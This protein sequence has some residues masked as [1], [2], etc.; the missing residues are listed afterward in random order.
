MSLFELLLPIFVSSLN[1][2]VIT[3]GSEYRV[4]CLRRGIATDF[5]NLCLN[6]SLLL[7]GLWHRHVFTHCLL[8]PQRQPRLLSKGF[9]AFIITLWE[10]PLQRTFRLAQLWPMP[11]KSSK[12]NAVPEQ[13]SRSQ[14][15]E[16]FNCCV[17]DFLVLVGF[18]FVFWGG[19]WDLLCC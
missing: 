12:L 16:Q 15:H 18:F 17:L 9:G 8:K 4:T 3:L 2:A 5:K 11:R 7:Y 19:F 1:H 10:W 14:A 6:K 13:L